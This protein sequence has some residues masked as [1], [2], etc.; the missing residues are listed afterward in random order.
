MNIAVSIL[1]FNK[2]YCNF[3]NMIYFCSKNYAIISH[4]HPMNYKHNFGMTLIGFKQKQLVEMV[5]KKKNCRFW[6]CYL[7][8]NFMKSWILCISNFSNIFLKN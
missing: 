4:V 5:L 1:N 3:Y 7:I 2:K 8:I 6:K